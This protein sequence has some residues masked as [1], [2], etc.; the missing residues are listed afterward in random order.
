MKTAPNASIVLG[1]TQDLPRI[2]EDMKQQFP[3]CELYQLKTIVQL[4]N[5]NKYKILL[6]KRDEDQVL[7]GYALV[8]MIENSNVVWLDFL[9]VL[10]EYQSYGYGN[11]L[12]T[13]LWQKYCGPFDGIMFSVE[14]VSKTDP[15]LAQQQKRR[16][17]F[18]ENLGSHRLHAKFLLPCDDNNLP[19]YLYFKPRRKSFV[20]NRSVQIQAISQMYDYCFFYLKHRNSLLPLYK[21]TIVD[22][23]FVS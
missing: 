14:Y 1:S 5:N 22:E 8:Y 21:Q 15:A 17:S 2:Y 9:A 12:F 20:I 10:K 16:L 11:A 4:I 23:Q 7:I 18:Y 13:A 6:F 19:M 3:P